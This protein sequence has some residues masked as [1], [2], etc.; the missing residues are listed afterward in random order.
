MLLRAI[1]GV[2]LTVV[3]LAL[4][5]KR[6][7]FLFSIARS[8]KPA[9]G[10]TKD[11]PKRVEA[12]AIEVL[13]QK[14]LLKW[15]IPGLAHVF[16][17]WGFLV[18]GLTILE[19]YG[20]LFIAD[21]AVPV[22]GTW[23]IVGFLEDLFGV[24]VL[25][26][27]IMF[28][29]LRLKN[30]P[31]THGRD[32]RF[33][34]SHTKGAWLIL[35]MIFNVVWTLFLYRG[36]QINTGVFP[37]K[38]GA[39]ASEWTASLLAP[40]GEGANEWLE[41]I[42]IWLQIGVVL[43]FLLIVLHSKHLHIG[44][45]PI[46]VYTSRRP[47]AL[48]PLLPIMYKGEPVNFEDPP[49]DATFG[50]GHIGDFTWKN[51]VDFMA[52]TECGRCQSQCPAW[53]TGKPLSPKLLMMNLRDTMFTQAP[54]LL[55]ANGEHPGLG[56]LH[57]QALAS[58]SAEVRAE[59]ER[60]FIG[61]RAGSEHSADDGYTFDGHRTTGAEL[62]I[63]DEDVLWSCTM[64]GACVNQC[65]VDIEHIDH[66]ADMR[67]NQV[68][69]AT[70]FPSELNGLFK[71]I[72]SKGNPWGM[73]AG[74]RNN[75]M[76]EVDFEVRVFGANGEETIP[77]DVDYLFWVGCAGAFEDRAKR[78]TKAVAELFNIAGVNFMVLGDGETCTG[79]P[80]R[81]AGNEF[82]FQM[83]GM[84]NVEML[85]EIKAT[86]IVVTC[87]HCL[88]TLNREYPQLGGNYEVVHHT[89]LLNDLVKAGRLTPV[90]SVNEKVTY[91]DPCYLGRHNNVYVPPRDLIEATGADKVEME[92]R[93]EKSFC[94]GAGGA[95]MW[96]EEKIGT[97]VNK[98]R[99]DEAIAT[100]A[101]KIAVACPFCSV[102]LNDAVTSRQQEGIGVGIEVVDVATLLLAAAK[103]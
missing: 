98:N 56:E 99:G 1:V 87:P 17:F 97:Q 37:F 14:K 93:G 19:A 70:E 8:G 61:A 16:A 75:W 22:I 48:G 100:G 66:I 21:F 51:Y 96:M 23:P 15:T 5:G 86:K 69:I 4:A 72:E 84:Q 60:P 101:S 62:P 55:A 3:I 26:G 47:N 103:S 45:A 59:V 54:Y 20:A 78:T 30:N 42:G 90:K 12:E 64:C 73:N 95:R 6:G 88:N 43:V 40:L 81:R 82:L 76:T 24:L 49:D 25:V 44:A 41:T 57:E 35:F 10:R 29:I 11:A 68:M 18:L 31:A 67:R 91:H 63:I 50:K 33:F 94:C 83:Q 77:E 27:I 53:N 52:C 79:D 32:S 34:G 36:A 65:P 9:V 38:S 2:L 58:V 39:F 92:R 74:D 102:M 7:W 46:N 85:N 28:A 89:Q 71:N 80:A 13:G